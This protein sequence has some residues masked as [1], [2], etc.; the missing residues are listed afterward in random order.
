MLL[1]LLL[2]M[3]VA[4]MLAL[5]LQD[6]ATARYPGIHARKFGSHAHLFGADVVH[7]QVY[8]VLELIQQGG[9]VALTVHC[10]PACTQTW[11]MVVGRESGIRYVKVVGECSEVASTATWR[12]GCGGREGRGEAQM[13]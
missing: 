3:P 9:N 5:L 6:A 8:V 10:V 11:D 4:P 12:K 13:P 2:V 1:L 7:A